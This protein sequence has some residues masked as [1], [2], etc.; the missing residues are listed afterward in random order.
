MEILFNFNNIFFEAFPLL[1]DHF[2]APA[3]LL[4]HYP[5]ADT[6]FNLFASFWVHS[7]YLILIE[8]LAKYRHGN[9]SC[10]SKV[11]GIWSDKNIQVLLNLHT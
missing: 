11:K 9:T 4:F 6:D 1:L 5:V 8:K 10:G 7:S 3:Y 2:G